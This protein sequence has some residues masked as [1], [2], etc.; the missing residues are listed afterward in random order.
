MPKSMWIL[1]LTNLF[2][3]MSH[4]CYNLY[5]TDYVG[6]AVF[7]GSPTAPEGSDERIAYEEGVRFG[8]WGLSIYSFS[9]A[10]Y[11]AVVDKLIK[12]FG[13]KKVYMGGC[14][15]YAIGMLILALVPTKAGVLALSTT[16]GII[17]A[18]LFTMPF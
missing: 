3:W 1:C 7:G 4:L 8:C 11:S 6:Q 18:T 5:F 15:G 9:C 13:V 2:C 16:A 12:W 14:L 10:T 17:Y